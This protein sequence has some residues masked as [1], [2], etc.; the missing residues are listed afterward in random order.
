M[1]RVS[2]TAM[3]LEILEHAKSYMIKIPHIN[4]VQKIIGAISMILSQG[5]SIN[6]PSTSRTT[7]D[8]S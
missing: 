2:T 4:N 5:V 1:F 3:M 6:E 7:L 8:N